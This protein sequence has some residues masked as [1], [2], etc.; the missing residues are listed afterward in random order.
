[1][2]VVP[3]SPEPRE[4]QA[5][6]SS[7][8]RSS[9]EQ[10]ADTGIFCYLNLG[11]QTEYVNLFLNK[12]GRYGVTYRL[13]N[14]LN[15]QTSIKKRKNCSRK[16]VFRLTESKLLKSRL[17]KIRALKLI[18]V[19]G[20]RR[21]PAHIGSIFWKIC[22]HRKRKHG[23]SRMEIINLGNNTF[24]GVTLLFLMHSYTG[25]TEDGPVG[26]KPQRKEPPLRLE[27]EKSDKTGRMPSSRNTLLKG[28]GGPGAYKLNLFDRVYTLKVLNDE[29]CSH[30]D[31]ILESRRPNG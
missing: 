28:K 25:A 4:E 27:D 8:G 30:G 17:D 18:Q 2:E 3:P 13:N 14:A 31:C 29:T 26:S 15:M 21:S 1:M 23:Y 6:S 10:R 5:V 22:I 11:V 12:D 24:E 19:R 20:N 9:R 7:T 16:T